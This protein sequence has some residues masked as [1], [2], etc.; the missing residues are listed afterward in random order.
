MSVVYHAMPSLCIFFATKA[1]HSHCLVNSEAA[2]VMQFN[3]ESHEALTA[4]VRQPPA[5]MRRRAAAGLERTRSLPSASDAA[6]MNTSLVAD[7]PAAT[8]RTLH[9]PV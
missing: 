3:S 5:R 6:Y 8:L 7:Q 4:V 9:P 2:S 1:G